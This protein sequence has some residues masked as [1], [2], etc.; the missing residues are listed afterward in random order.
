MRL[1]LV[2]FRE[3][4]LL[5]ALEHL[6]LRIERL[7]DLCV[8]IELFYLRV[9]LFPQ[10]PDLFLHSGALILVFHEERIVH[11]DQL[12]LTGFKSLIALLEHVLVGL[13]GSLVALVGGHAL[14]KGLIHVKQGFILRVQGL[15][16]LNLASLPLKVE[17]GRHKL[18]VS[19]LFCAVL[20]SQ[21]PN[22]LVFLGVLRLEQTDRL[23][24]PVVLLSFDHS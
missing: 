4:A 1:E 6:N 10:H 15:L 12:D 13:L 5:K 14:F 8:P 17:V 20:L 3:R 9:E 23:L 21:G 11:L 2:N 18:L 7:D 19:A 16:V 24:L 22:R